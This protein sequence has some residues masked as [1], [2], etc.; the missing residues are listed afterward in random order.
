MLIG[1]AGMFAS[2]ARVL[3]CGED[4]DVD[5][6]NIGRG[7]FFVSILYVLSASML[8]LRAGEWAMMVLSTLA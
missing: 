1:E 5:R 3:N 7:V 2:S 4:V 8:L 6:F